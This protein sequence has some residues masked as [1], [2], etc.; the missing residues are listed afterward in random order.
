MTTLKWLVSISRLTVSALAILAAL[1]QLGLAATAGSNVSSI[2][3]KVVADAKLVVPVKVNGAGPFDFVLDTG[4]SETIIDSDLAAQLLLPVTGSRIIMGLRKSSILLTGHA[5]SLEVAEA[6]VKDLDLSVVQL[7]G[8]KS[9]YSKGRGILGEDF[10]RNFDLLLDNRHHLLQM[11]QG[12]GPMA[13]ALTGEHVPLSQG[14]YQG[15]PTPNLLMLIVKVP[16]LA[17]RPLTV[18]LDSGAFA[19]IL[20]WSAYREP[21]SLRAEGHREVFLAGTD[22]CWMDERRVGALSVGNMFLGNV[23]VMVSA[24][25]GIADMDGLLPTSIFQSV[26]ISHSGGYAIFNPVARTTLAKKFP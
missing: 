16:E 4:T 3:F 25:C 7:S 1:G 15:E 19:P 20:F 11:E 23:M 14:S 17:T 5:D 18:L 21:Q 13:A 2:H 6:T 8:L 9:R 26:Y 22:R 24:L 12:T 10:L